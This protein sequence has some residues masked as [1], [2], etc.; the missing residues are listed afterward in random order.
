M[1][2]EQ[3]TQRRSDAGKRAYQRRLEKLEL[4]KLGAEQAEEGYYA[5]QKMFCVSA[6]GG[7]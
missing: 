2:L 3:E 4:M 1:I 5:Q 7:R 6:G